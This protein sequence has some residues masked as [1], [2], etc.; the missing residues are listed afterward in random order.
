MGVEVVKRV[1]NDEEYY[2]VMNHT[3]EVKIF[4]GITFKAYES[5]I[6]KK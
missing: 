5:K 1:V 4:D 6:I 3:Q 2:F